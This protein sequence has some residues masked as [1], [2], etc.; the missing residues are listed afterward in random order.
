MTQSNQRQFS[1]R[2]VETKILDQKYTQFSLFYRPTEMA[3]VHLL[4]MYAHIEREVKNS[5]EFAD[6]SFLKRVSVSQSMLNSLGHCIRWL[7]DPPRQPIALPLATE[8]ELDMEALQWL[9]WGKDYARLVADHSAWTKNIVTGAIDNSTK[10]I[11]FTYPANQNLLSLLHQSAAQQR[12]EDDHSAEIPFAALEPYFAEWLQSLL[13]HRGVFQAPHAI[14]DVQARAIALSWLA[15][16]VWPELRPEMALGGYTLQDFRQLFAGLFVNSL[17]VSW[18]EDR[19][20][21]LH[22]PENEAGSIV[23]IHNEREMSRW[24]ASLT[25]I[26]EPAA[27][28]LLTDLTFDAR[29]WH[30]SL[31]NQPFVRSRT[32]QYF[33]LG[34][35][36]SS[37]DPARMLA[38]ALIHGQKERYYNQIGRQFEEPVLREMEAVLTRRGFAVLRDRSIKSGGDTITPDLLVFDQAQNTLLVADYKH[39]LTPLSTLDVINRRRELQEGRQGIAQVRR[40][41]RFVAANRAVVSR[42]LQADVSTAALVGVLIFRWPMPIPLEETPDV[43]LSDWTSLKARLET[44]EPTTLPE[45]VDWMRARPDCGIELER[46]WYETERIE[47][48]DWAYLH[49][50]LVYHQDIVG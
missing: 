22:G 28:A 47:V 32:G 26:T 42:Q 41:L 2:E 13:E 40:Y 9:A 46:W 34:R 4:R 36:I 15:R 21:V 20:D 39:H 5:E 43:I 23:I 33:L 8:R 19:M 25:G 37:L 18:A 6:M 45:L 17:F 35:L 29:H 11:T 48:D 7:A 44:P 10:T 24:L 12:I 31:A 49:P 27:R 16:T 38:G 3:L 30:S 1:I 14:V 50:T